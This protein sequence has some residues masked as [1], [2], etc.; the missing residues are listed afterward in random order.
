MT[1]LK[2]T[3][4]LFNGIEIDTDSLPGS[5]GEF[6]TALT[7]SLDRWS[8]NGN[9][10]AWLNLPIEKADFVPIAVDA[11]F[12]YHHS[13]E[14]YLQLVRT[15]TPDAYVPSYATHYI[16]AG[17]VVINEQNEL[18][19]VVE[20]YRRDRSR[21]YYKLPGGA[22]HPS[23]HIADAVVREIYEETGVYTKFEAVVCFRH[24]HGYRYD[25]S[26]IYFVC[27]LQPTSHEITIHDGE[28]DEAL[29][30]P[31]DEYLTSEYVGKFNREIVRAAVQSPGLKHRNV[32]GYSGG[33]PREMLFPPATQLETN[34]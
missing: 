22:L 30:M 33:R 16:G 6:Q 7:T 23:E 17:G 28:I 31:V 26:D 25:K 2:S 14:G 5:S 24:W 3:V 12:I 10:L 29:W 19:V 9:V 8:D 13:G 27:R 34:V 4:N 11:G 15:L 1:E 18:L 32:D 20:R 21:P